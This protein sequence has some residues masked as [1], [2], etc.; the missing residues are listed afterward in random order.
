VHVRPVAEIARN[1][2]SGKKKVVETRL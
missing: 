2:I 1:P